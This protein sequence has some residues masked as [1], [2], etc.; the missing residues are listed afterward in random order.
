MIAGF[1]CCWKVLQLQLNCVL[2]SVDRFRITVCLIGV[3]EFEICCLV[4]PRMKNCAI[5]SVLDSEIHGWE[6]FCCV[7]S[8]CEG[9]YNAFSL[10]SWWGYFLLVEIPTAI[11]LLLYSNSALFLLMAMLVEGFFHFHK[12]GYAE[13]ELVSS[14]SELIICSP[15][16]FLIWAQ[17]FFFIWLCGRKIIQELHRH[18]SITLIIMA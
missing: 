6:G 7:F 17:R 15:E 1:C 3:L 8:L 12:P 2:S 14:F 16:I 4:G 18:N 13:L 10:G 11:F 5:G 9:Y